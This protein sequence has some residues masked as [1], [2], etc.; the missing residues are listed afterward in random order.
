MGLKQ[1]SLSAGVQAGNGQEHDLHI[2]HIV[3]TPACFGSIAQSPSVGSSQPWTAETAFCSRCSTAGFTEQQELMCART[4]FFCMLALALVLML[5]RL[6]A[7]S[8]S[9]PN[10]LQLTSTN[11]HNYS[12]VLHADAYATRHPC[13]DP[14]LLCP[15]ACPTC[16]AQPCAKS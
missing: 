9:L 5:S 3:Q 2:T 8:C 4:T 11:S 1:T 12:P 10:I 15:A 13:V 7:V 16:R 14:V 6:V